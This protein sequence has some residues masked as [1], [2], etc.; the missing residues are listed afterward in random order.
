MRGDEKSASPEVRIPEPAIPHMRFDL[1]LPDNDVFTRSI[2]KLQG[3]P[4]KPFNSR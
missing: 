2:L 4:D 3:E 1:S